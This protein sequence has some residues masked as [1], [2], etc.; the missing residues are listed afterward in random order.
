MPAIIGFVTRDNVSTKGLVH[1]GALAIPS[2]YI[3]SAPGRRPASRPARD[4]LAH[5]A[6]E[7]LTPAFAH[8]ESSHASGHALSLH[9]LRRLA[10]A[11]HRSARAQFAPCA[12]LTTRWRWSRRSTTPIDCSGLPAP[13]EKAT[14]VIARLAA[15]SAAAKRQFFLYTL[16]PLIAAAAR[17]I[18]LGM[19]PGYLMLWP[20]G[21]RTEA[22]SRLAHASWN[23]QSGDRAVGES[24][25]AAARAQRSRRWRWV[26]L[27]RRPQSPGFEPDRLMLSVSGSTLDNAS[28]GGSGSLTWL[29]SFNLDTL[30]RRRR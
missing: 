4:G 5:C 2:F 27:R 19:R 8:R 7:R 17:R 26:A 10:P 24:A 9:L 28:G 14:G 6:P 18:G 12:W 15:A 20:T 30:A 29:H 13:R 23:V 11:V 22:W 16:D 25:A 1:R 3:A 21:Y